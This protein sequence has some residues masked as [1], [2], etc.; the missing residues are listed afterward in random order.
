MN[1]KVSLSPSGRGSEVSLVCTQPRRVAAISVAE[2]VAW[3]RDEHLGAS[4]GYQVKMDS[5]PPRAQV[6]LGYQVKMDSKTPWVF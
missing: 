4:V 2:R 6:N 3:E 1:C 5:K